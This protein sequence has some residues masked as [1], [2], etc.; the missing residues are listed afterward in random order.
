MTKTEFAAR[1]RAL[2]QRRKMTQEALAEASGLA[3][4]TVRRLEH[5]VFNPSL[6]TMN[7]LA[8]GLDLTTIQL[9]VDNYDRADDLAE[10]IRRLPEAEQRL[11]CTMLGT[12]FVYAAT[13]H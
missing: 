11:A 2:R 1:V 13:G 8:K 6:D 4:D 12:L 3:T 7:K 5:G 10:M 9:L